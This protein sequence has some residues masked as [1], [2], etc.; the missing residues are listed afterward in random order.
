MT[1]FIEPDLKEVQIKLSFP[2][3][4]KSADRAKLKDISAMERLGLSTMCED[5]AVGYDLPF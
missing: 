2:L 1:V 5:E 3:F 4:F